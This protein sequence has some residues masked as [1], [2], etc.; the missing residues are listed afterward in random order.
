MKGIELASEARQN[1]G[2]RVTRIDIQINQRLNPTNENEQTGNSTLR[3]CGQE[4]EEEQNNQAHQA[5]GRG[6]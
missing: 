4:V 1:L 5:S 6:Y 3:K 2:V